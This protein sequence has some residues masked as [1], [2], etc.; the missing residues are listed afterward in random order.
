MRIVSVLFFA[1]AL[2]NATPL[3]DRLAK[4]GKKVLNLLC[5]TDKIPKEI[6]QKSLEDLI[7]DIEKSKACEDISKRDLKAVAT[8][9]LNKNHLETSATQINQID[10]PKDAKCPVCGMFVAK[11]PKWVALIEVEKKEA[12]F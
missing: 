2:L 7:R 8:Y 12:L 3:V 9:L 11:Y 6:N 10:V 5:D 4:R 1:I